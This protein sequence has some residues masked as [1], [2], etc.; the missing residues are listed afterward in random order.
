MA[1]QQQDPTRGFLYKQGEDPLFV[2]FQYNPTSISDKRSV[3][4]A[5]ITAPALLMPVK[6]YT[7][8]GDRVISFSIKIDGLFE[9]P[10][11]IDK[12]E[13]GSITPELNKYRAFLYPDTSN[14]RDAGA[15]FVSLY[16][17]AREFKAPPTCLFGFGDRVIECI[18]TEVG[19]NETLFN[20]DLAPLR[21]DVSITLQEIIP[22]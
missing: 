3:E 7:Q 16:D 6:Q 5:S 22:Y 14:W 21:A 17:D 10:I 1:M 9:G 2:E 8:G 13:N 11:Q 4:Y 18:V 19:I 15:S 12:D 20:L